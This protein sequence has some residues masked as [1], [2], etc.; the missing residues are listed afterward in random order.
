M[1]SVNTFVGMTDGKPSSKVMKPPGGG[2]S[3][4]FGGGATNGD[5]I[6]GKRKNHMKSD[7]FG[8]GATNGTA[9]PL[10]QRPGQDSAHRLFGE[11]DPIDAAK[12]KNHMQSDVIN[13]DDSEK[14][15]EN[16][17]ENDEDEEEENGDEK[18]EDCATVNG[19][20]EKVPE[21]TKIATPEKAPEPQPQQPAPRGRV[22]PG[23]FSTKLW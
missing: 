22:P 20:A 10:R 14:N 9:A 4:I 11:P 2:C 18:K 13:A 23:G 21:P 6:S 19:E 7:P 1:S 12:K 17:K 5:D 3:D 8:G 15:K 16:V